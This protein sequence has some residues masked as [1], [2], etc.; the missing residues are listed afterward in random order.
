MGPHGEAECRCRK[1]WKGR[2]CQFMEEEHDDVVVFDFGPEPVVDFIPVP[3]LLPPPLSGICAPDLCRH[4]GQCVEVEAGRTYRCVCR[5]GYSG[6]TCQTVQDN[7]GCAGGCLHGGTC[8]SVRGSCVCTEPWIGTNCDA[9][10]EA[11]ICLAFG[12]CARGKKC[13]TADDAWMDDSDRNEFRPGWT[14]RCV[15]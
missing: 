9:K 10:D 12:K 2:F 3:I 7:A 1:G 5:D 13:V 8:D 14:A 6:A 15:V 11:E 4:E